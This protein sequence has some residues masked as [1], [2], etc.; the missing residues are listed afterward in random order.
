MSDCNKSTDEDE[1]VASKLMP[2]VAKLIHFESGSS[3]LKGSTS[4]SLCGSNSEK[5]NVEMHKR[6]SLHG[7]GTH[8]PPRRAED[9]VFQDV[10]KKFLRRAVTGKQSPSSPY[11]SSPA[12]RSAY[13][14]FKENVRPKALTLAQQGTGLMPPQKMAMTDA[15]HKAANELMKKTSRSKFGFGQRGSVNPRIQG[16]ERYKSNFLSLRLTQHATR[17]ELPRASHDSHGS[18]GSRYISDLAMNSKGQKAKLLRQTEP[19]NLSEIQEEFAKLDAEALEEEEIP[20]THLTR[21]RPILTSKTLMQHGDINRGENIEV[22]SEENLPRIEQDGSTCL[23]LNEIH[24]EARNADASTKPFEKGDKRNG[25][26]GSDCNVQK[27]EAAKEEGV[28]SLSLISPINPNIVAHS[29][30]HQRTVGIKSP[31]RIEVSTQGAS[32]NG[33]RVSAVLAKSHV[34]GHS[35]TKPNVDRS[36]RMMAQE[37]NA[38]AAHQDTVLDHTTLHRDAESDP[39]KLHQVLDNEDVSHI[40]LQEE[41]FSNRD[42]SATPPRNPMLLTGVRYSRKWINPD[43]SQRRLTFDSANESFSRASNSSDDSLSSVEFKGRKN[44]A[45]IFQTDILNH[46]MDHDFCAHT[47]NEFHHESRN[48]MTDDVAI[49]QHFQAEELSHEIIID[50]KCAAE[51][52]SGDAEL[53]GKVDGTDSV[54]CSS[55][56][57]TGVQSEGGAEREALPTHS[58]IRGKPPDIEAADVEKDPYIFTLSPQAKPAAGCK[59]IR[60]LGKRTWANL[61]TPIDGGSEWKEGRRVSTRIKSRPLNWWRGEKMLYGRIHSST[62][63]NR[64]NSIFYDLKTLVVVLIAKKSQYSIEEDFIKNSLSRLEFFFDTCLTESS[65]HHI[66]CFINKKLECSRINNLFINLFYIHVSSECNSNSMCI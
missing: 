58:Q 5:E 37:A 57:K 35:S 40:P 47:T 13:E 32:E 63:V 14:P 11:Y 62:F 15:S 41:S 23:S 19:V 38:N 39:P 33:T 51:R 12:A 43:M 27:T 60:G 42:V 54:S 3:E 29:R 48:L 34:E 31:R 53:N 52:P 2:N 17:V 10:A 4:M 25:T 49:G 18:R 56:P 1:N 26:T 24:D 59:K 6:E 30:G 50:L 21:I 36:K 7:N 8:S 55:K 16:A 9:S 61:G 44:S 66:T 65:L 45:I 64:T 28:A 46:D 20:T 22:Q